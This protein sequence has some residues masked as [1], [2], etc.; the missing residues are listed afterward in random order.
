MSV[1]ASEINAPLDGYRSCEERRVFTA[2][3][4]VTTAERTPRAGT[5]PKGE[6]IIFAALDQGTSLCFREEKFMPLVKLAYAATNT[7][8]VELCNKGET[9]S[10]LLDRRVDFVIAT[11]NHVNLSSYYGHVMLPPASLCFISR[12]AM[13]LRPSFS[14]MWL[15]FLQVSLALFPFVLVFLLLVTVQA[16]RHSA[17]TIDPSALIMFFLATYLGQSPVA[18]NQSK[19]AL[20]RLSLV[21]WMFAMFILVQFSRTEI[22]ASRSIPALS[23]EMR[24]V[25]EFKARLDAGKTLPCT[26][27]FVT[28]IIDKFSGNVPHLVSLRQAL[29]NCDKTCLT[30]NI[31]GFCFPLAE[32]GSHAIVE[33]CRLFQKDNGCSAGLVVSDEALVSYLKWLPTHIR[34][35][36]RHQHRRLILALEESGL[37]WEVI[38]RRYSPCSDRKTLATFDIPFS[39]YAAVFFAGCGISLMAFGAEVLCQRYSHSRRHHAR[40]L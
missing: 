27:F 20:V 15:S 16:G 13:P 25:A 17:C 12:R 35:P 26:H 24:H 31:G 5:Y 32:R 11:S 39:D 18:V 2:A 36:M 4:D 40:R 1:T 3:E 21:A 14:S 9:D 23:S 22:T 33:M 28:G 34:F 8:L 30:N 37:T 7:T 19:S 10:L 6:R 29:K 38:R